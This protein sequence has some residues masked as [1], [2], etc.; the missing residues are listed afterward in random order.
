MVPA[1]RPAA[2]SPN[3]SNDTDSGAQKGRANRWLGPP[4]PSTTCSLQQN[5][6]DIDETSAQKRLLQAHQ[7]RR[8]PQ[9]LV[10]GGGTNFLATQA[11]DV[12]PRVLPSYFSGA[13]HGN[14]QIPVAEPKAVLWQ[15][16]WPPGP[17]RSSVDRGAGRKP[18]KEPQPPVLR[19]LDRTRAILWSA[20]LVSS[21]PSTRIRHRGAGAGWTSSGFPGPRRGT[22]LPTGSFGPTTPADMAR[23][24][25]VV[26]LFVGPII[27]RT[28][29]YR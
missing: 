11:W 3:K 9:R 28:L 17:R 13:D 1:R 23:V 15:P 12:P 24:T 29:V 22:R 4:V 26:V 7:R 27:L 10:Q 5:H 20:L 14:W 6:V 25:G 16:G 2:R 8:S 18:A 19:A 21:C